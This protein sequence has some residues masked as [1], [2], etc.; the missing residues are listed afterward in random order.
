M[1]PGAT[2]LA[3]YNNYA[4]DDI[5]ML[6]MSNAKIAEVAR[7]I[8]IY[9]I[10]KESKINC[11][12]SV[13]LQMGSWKGYPHLGPLSRTDRSCRFS[14]AESCRLIGQRYCEGIFVSATYWGRS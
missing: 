10:V 12:K 7:E 11:D 14:P 1:L 5:T 13:G 6:V 3:K 4:D 2:T 9:K 8:Q